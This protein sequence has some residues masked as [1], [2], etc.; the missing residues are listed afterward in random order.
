MITTTVTTL[1]TVSTIKLMVDN[2]EYIM[3][4][5]DD[6]IFSKSFKLNNVG[7]YIIDLDITAGDNT[8]SYKDVE[9]ITTRATSAAITAVKYSHLTDDVTQID[10]Q[11][12]IQGEFASYRIN[13]GTSE[14]TLNQQVISTIPNS[15]I[16]IDTSIDTYVQIQ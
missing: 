6:G 14:S 5:V 11:W 7:Q 10:L 4:K 1:D 9:K 12:S 3:D 15:K 13:Y 16:T 2:Q 8:R